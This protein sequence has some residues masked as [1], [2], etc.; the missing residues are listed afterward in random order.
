MNMPVKKGTSKPEYSHEEKAAIVERVCE[1][2]ESQ[3]ATLESCCKAVGI[4]Y[5]AF[6][7]WT[8]QFGDF[9]ERY[10]KAKEKQDANYW[11]NIIRPLTKTSLQRL[12]EGEETEETQIADLHF[13]GGLTKEKATTIKRGK[14]QPNPS[15]VIFTLK[16]LYPDMFAERHEHTGKD[17]QPL[18]ILPKI[19]FVFRPSTDDVPHESEPKGERQTG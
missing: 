5:Q 18:E 14:T 12:L 16:G 4:S 17:G 13:R 15:A 2:Y 11:E 9:G 19:E 8:V 6:N 3:N 1:L 10:K 7:L